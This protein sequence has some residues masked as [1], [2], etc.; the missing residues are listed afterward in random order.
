[1]AKMIGVGVTGGIAAYKI[2]DLVS[3]LSKHED[4]EVTVVM[5][6]AA[7]RFVSPLTFKTLANREVHLDLWQESPGHR[8]QHIGVAQSLDLFVV[9]PATAN[10]IGKMAAGIADNLLTTMLLATPAPILLV[11]SMN[12]GMYENPVVQRNLQTL[13]DLGHQIL[14][15]GAGYLACGDAGKGRL[16]EVEEIYAF[17]LDMIYPRQD[18]Q[19]MKIMV[20][21]G[22]TC[23]N[24]DPVRYIT[25]RGS[26]KM[27]FAVARSAHQ[28]GADV[29]LVSGP[30]P[31]PPPPGVR[32]YSV[33]SAREMCD[34]MASLQN[35]CDVIIG[36][37]AVGDFRLAQAAD[38]K[39]KKT[40]DPDERIILELVK[41]PDILKTLGQRK[42]PG[43]IMVGFAAE[44][45]DLIPNALKKLESKNLDLIVAND[46]TMEGAGFAIDTN[47]VTII[48]R[49][50]E[51]R[52]YP[53]M[54]K[55]Q[56]AEAILDQVAA[57][58]SKLEL[59][60]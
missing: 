41:N 15:P 39:I 20:N 12:S 1:M 50:G 24:I 3:R 46:V 45:Q 11:P 22:T 29:I 18:L 6:E 14:E 4:I 42:R 21:A 48:T 56:V 27:G 9:A 10:I 51:Q 5:T 16:P 35:E 49:A 38:Q 36:A 52:P 25:N 8:V 26:G 30:S 32:F 53:K 60:Q 33:W 54:S 34:R 7:T 31:L 17:I 28:R 19:G 58:A 59:K 43:Q 57:L 13:R 23:E 47:I 2:A 55:D 40:D 37:A 44:T